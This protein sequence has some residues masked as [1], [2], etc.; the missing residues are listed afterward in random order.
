MHSIWRIILER[1]VYWGAIIDYDVLVYRLILAPTRPVQFVQR[2][3]GLLLLN[4]SRGGD[5]VGGPSLTPRARVQLPTVPIQAGF[6][7]GV[8]IVALPSSESAGCVSYVL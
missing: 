2:L 4:L 5:G 1:S 6:L 8:L 3:K 7:D